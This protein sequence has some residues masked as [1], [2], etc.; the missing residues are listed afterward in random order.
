MSAFRYVVLGAGRQG[1]AAAIDLVRNGEAGA[2]LLVDSDR[3]RCEEVVHEVNAHRG[4]SVARSKIGGVEDPGFLEAAL[5]KA[6]G[7]LSALPYRYNPQIAAACVRARCHHADLGGDPE[8]VQ[9]VLDMH[10]AATKAQVSL[11]PDCGLA[12]GLS[13]LLVAR[14]LELA[15][16]RAGE[17]PAGGWRLTVRCGG[18]PVEPAGPLGYA[19]VFSPWGLLKEYEGEVPVIRGGAHE[20]RE[21]LSESEEVVFPAPPGSCEAFHTVGGASTIPSSFGDRLEFY[22]Y[23]TVRYPGH[24][25][26]IVLLRELGLL[27]EDPVPSALGEGEMAPRNLLVSLLERALPHD[28]PDLVVLRVCI[29]GCGFEIALDVREFG[30]E[31]LGLS[32]MERC[33]GFSAA[34]IL[35]AQVRGEVRHGADPPERAVSAADHIADVERRG[36]SVRIR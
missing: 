17:D 5:E 26:K 32:A 22:D 12:P 28:V 14:A 19:L 11:V 10:E 15:R 4:T 27:G 31:Q 29:Q 20:S 3:D 9:A 21:A 1:R 7:C 24:R 2:L 35:H 18:L 25:E 34:A 6:D 16:K 13:N 33:T 23:K 30:D 36:I 8:T